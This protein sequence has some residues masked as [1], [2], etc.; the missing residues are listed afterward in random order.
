MIIAAT[1]ELAMLGCFLGSA[2]TRTRVMGVVLWCLYGYY[3]A[4][5]PALRGIAKWFHDQ[6]DDP[7]PGA[8]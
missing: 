6:D 4:T 7:P 1:L 5:W 8:A 2:D 3:S